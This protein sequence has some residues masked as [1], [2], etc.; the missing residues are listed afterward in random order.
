MLLIRMATVYETLILNILKKIHG[1]NG[2]QKKKSLSAT[3]A[4]PLCLIMSNGVSANGKIRSGL[5]HMVKV[6]YTNKGT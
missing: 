6:N 5:L 4:K 1:R 3:P 2:T